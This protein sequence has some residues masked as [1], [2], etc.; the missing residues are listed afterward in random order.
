MT[1]EYTF[2]QGDFVVYPTHGVGKV[3]GL[4]ETE[5]CGQML[6][7]LQV[8]FNEKK[9]EV[10]KIPMTNMGK[11]SLRHLSSKDVMD[12]AL[13]TLK[14]KPQVKKTI[15]SRRSQEY[16]AKINSGDPCLVAEV[17]RDLNKLNDASEQSPSERQVFE[18]AFGRLV[19]EYAACENIELEEAS[20]RIKS[21]LIKDKL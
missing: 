21:M 6:E 11:T 10:V 9:H 13:S 19:G 2:N 3:V 7:L 12:S 14:K 8:S 15:W 20:S 5:V 4:E 17:V 16:S 1:K 18:Q